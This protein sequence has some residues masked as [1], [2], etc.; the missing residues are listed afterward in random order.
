MIITIRVPDDTVKMQF[1]TQ[2]GENY[3]M[4]FPVKFGDYVSVQQ[5]DKDGGAADEDT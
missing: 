4:W 5:E 3:E 2:T 1:A